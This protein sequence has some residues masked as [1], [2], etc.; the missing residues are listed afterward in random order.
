MRFKK[1]TALFLGIFVAIAFLDQIIYRVLNVQ[2]NQKYI[3][4]TEGFEYRFGDSPIDSHGRPEWTY[5]GQT[6]DWVTKTTDKIPVINRNDHNYVWIRV[7]LPKG[8]W[9]EP[10]LFI[11]RSLDIFEMYIDHERFYQFGDWGNLDRLMGYPSH[12]IP[13]PSDALGK[14]V[15]F[16]VYSTYNPIGLSPT[17]LLGNSK[18]IAVGMIRGDIDKYFIVVIF[19][20]MSL[21]SAIFY[22]GNRLEKGYLYFAWFSLSSGIVITTQQIKSKFIWNSSLFDYYLNIVVV[23]S[24]LI[25]FLLFVEFIFQSP[26]MRLIRW[27]RYCSIVFFIV[28]MIIT[29]I[30]PKLLIIYKLY[31]LG[32]LY[33]LISLVTVMIVLLMLLRTTHNAEKRIMVVGISIFTFISV[34]DRLIQSLLPF[35]YI[36]NRLKHNFDNFLIVSIHWE[37]SCLVITL[38]VI[39]VRRFHQVYKNNKLYAQQLIDKNA[40]LEKM[41]SLKNEFLAKTSHEL[42]TPLH[43]IMGIA[44]S[45]LD[46]AYGDMNEGLKRNLSMI[47]SSANRL[48]QLVN[49]I[50]DFSKLRFNEIR[51]QRKAVDAKE[52]TNL[53]IN[54]LMP[55]VHNKSITLINA[56]PNHLPLC[57]ADENRLQQ[58]LFNLIG[59]AIKFTEK[60]KVEVNGEVS[61]GMLIIHVKD[62]GIGIHSSR[63]QQIFDA[64][65]SDENGESLEANKGTGLGLSITKNLVELHGGTIEVRSELG[66]GSCFIFTLPLYEES[67]NTDNLTNEQISKEE[68]SHAD[69]LSLKDSSHFRKTAE[70]NTP[71][72]SQ[73]AHDSETITKTTYPHNTFFQDKYSWSATTQDIIA[74]PYRT[75][76]DAGDSVYILIVDDEMINIQV[77]FN[78]LSME[79]YT[80]MYATSGAE[81]LTILD[82]GFEPD[83]VLLDLMMPKMS[84]FQVVKEIRKEYTASE[85]PILLVTAQSLEHD[86]VRAFDLGANDYIIK[87]ISRGELLA[88]I[89]MH[90]QLTNSN[91]VLEQ[92]VRERTAVVNHLLNQMQHGFFSFGS[93]ML[94]GEEYSQ[95]CKT[96]FGEGIANH[97]VSELLFNE[98]D[99]QKEQFQSLMSCIMKSD[100][101]LQDIEPYID[102]LPETTIVGDKTYYLEYHFYCNEYKSQQKYCLI[103]IKDVTQGEFLQEQL[104]HQ[105]NQIRMIAQA[106]KHPEWV[107]Q[108]LI[109]LKRLKS[110]LFRLLVDCS[111][112]ELWGVYKDIHSVIGHFSFLLMNDTASKLRPIEQT[113]YNLLHQR[114]FVQGKAF[115]LNHKELELLNECEVKDM[116][117]LLEIFGEE[118]LYGQPSDSTPVSL[119]D[120]LYSYGEYAQQLAEGLGKS[121]GPIQII[122]EDIKLSSYEANTWLK[123]LGHLFRNI[124]EHAI[125]YPE[126]R[127][128]LDKPESGVIQC[129]LSSAQNGFVTL[130]IQDDGKG[131]DS[132]ALK[133]KVLLHKGWG[134]HKL[135]SLSE[136]EI[137]EFI[138]EEGLTTKDSYTENAGHGVGLSALKR[139]V[140]IADGVVTIQSAAGKGTSFTIHCKGK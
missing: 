95:V 128:T 41:D 115:Q 77:L 82:R 133:Q 1:Y 134:A 105:Q 12:F 114:V 22:W 92:T 5:N 46:G 130:K 108:S 94:I 2:D 11:Y 111:E 74:E 76:E 136:Q 66:Q 3:K 44:E 96:I 104:Q 86:M 9:K 140:Q 103:V 21:V 49:D 43:G 25:P 89:R 118:W 123:E 27:L 99:K 67:L 65:H 107:R 16:R 91:Y 62:S 135:Q 79:N 45:I 34:K 29:M 98:N 61:A 71:Y 63:H 119:I 97:E 60:G 19:L 10:T 56:M 116:S 127:R 110:Q 7:T 30:N 122:G 100:G 126:D 131:I 8:D 64:F 73:S 125:E 53:V 101:P 42:R 72:S 58:I 18:D 14:Q 75:S 50:L 35:L 33:I 78:Y 28:V 81:A 70:D 102:L 138:F 36:P 106:V 83:L 20:A 51:L 90:L 80:V 39:L 40:D 13:L 93:N 57:F 38:A 121:I 124:A 55:L 85:L 120:I 117:I 59:N 6:K 24:I 54:F 47:L 113:L 87:P 15:Y 112:R 69:I 137:L 84:G 37:L 26:K 129:V 132:R 32:S 88:R 109:D 139:A 17:I 48:A 4:L 68:K 23:F 52:I 31:E